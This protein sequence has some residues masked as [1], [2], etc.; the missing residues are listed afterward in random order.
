[1]QWWYKLTPSLDIFTMLANSSN[2]IFRLLQ[3]EPLLHSIFSLKNV[4]QIKT[5]FFLIN[6]FNIKILY[7][8]WHF[9]SFLLNLATSFCKAM[10]YLSKI[11]KLSFNPQGKI[12]NGNVCSTNITKKIHFI[13]GTSFVCISRYNIIVSWS[14]CIFSEFITFN[15]DKY[16]AHLKWSFPLI[17][18]NFSKNVEQPRV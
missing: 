17:E 14:Q 18:P 12:R 6:F 11:K 16:A 10:V 4:R 1:M 9:I 2:V 13:V 5:K 15:V 7:L 8:S 3:I